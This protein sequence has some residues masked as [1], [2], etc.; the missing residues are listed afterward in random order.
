MTIYL[1]FY[2]DYVN[3]KNYKVVF[4]VF[5][6]ELFAFVL[7][8]KKKGISSGWWVVRIE[9]DERC[10][11]SKLCRVRILDESIQRTDIEVAHSTQARDS[12]V[13]AASIKQIHSGIRSVSKM[14]QI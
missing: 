7:E 3:E 4:N 5:V 9:L 12:S 14:K 1:W 11:L 6:G 8:I 2:E 10:L 13:D